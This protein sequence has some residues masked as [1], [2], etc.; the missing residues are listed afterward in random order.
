MNM[1]A[2]AAVASLSIAR[3]GTQQ[4]Q[5]GPLEYFT[6]SVRID[7]LFQAKDTT[8]ASG[9]YVTFEPGARTAWHTHPRGQTG[10]PSDRF[11]Q[12][13]VP[14]GPRRATKGRSARPD[15]LLF[16]VK[17]GHVGPWRVMQGHTEPLLRFPP[18]PPISPLMTQFGCSKLMREGRRLETAGYHRAHGLYSSSIRGAFGSCSSSDW[19]YRM[20][21]RRNCGHDG[22]V[23]RGSVRSGKRLQ[24]AG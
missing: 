5:K 3:A 14:L 15:S 8:L 16:R 7:P 23:G 22:T 4:S 1:V 2:A 10:W 20:H 9:A 6:G 12:L 19:R 11:G 24:R 18:P 17:Q 21:P 13:R